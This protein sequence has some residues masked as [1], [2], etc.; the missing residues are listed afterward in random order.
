MAAS[1]DAGKPVEIEELPTLADSLGGGVGHANRYTFPMVRALVDDVILVTEAEI[2]AGIRHAYFDE[3]EVVEGA[4][5]V[6]IAALVAGRIRPS[7][8]VLALVSGR[9]IDMELHRRIAAGAN[10]LEDAA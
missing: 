1:L 5:A 9:N 6:G 3:R 2:A 10:G 8:P 7:G 4:G